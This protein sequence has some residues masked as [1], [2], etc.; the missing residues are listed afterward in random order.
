MSSIQKF[1]FLVLLTGGMSFLSAMNSDEK[2]LENF[3]VF[4]SVPLDLQNVLFER[5][6]Q[7]PQSWAYGTTHHIALVCKKFSFLY[8][9]SCAKLLFSCIDATKSVAVVLQRLHALRDNKK[10]KEFLKTR[11]VSRVLCDYLVTYCNEN[12]N[13]SLFD[14]LSP[15]ANEEELTMY[16]VQHEKGKE[17]FQY[18]LEEKWS[19]VTY[20][21]ECLKNNPLRY[22]IINF[23]YSFRDTGS[24]TTAPRVSLLIQAIL[25]EQMDVI[26]RL[27]SLGV[28]VNGVKFG[29][30]A[31]M[32]ALSNILVKYGDLVEG[33]DTVLSK[34]LVDKLIQAGAS[35]NYCTNL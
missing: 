3:T 33:R 13:E 26:D 8:D 30:S 7:D 28:D 32:V 29:P 25:C 10:F 2:I 21:L 18:S 31:L 14:L 22:P 23:I 1:L 35:V 16:K 27:L 20:Q 34:T 15:F 17:L 6:L 11:P 19:I 9:T 12:D 5:C 24:S 4:E